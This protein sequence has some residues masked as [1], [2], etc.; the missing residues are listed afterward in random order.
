[1]VG[2]KTERLTVGLERPI[3]D[4]SEAL[5]LELATF[6]RG[7]NSDGPWFFGG[8]V[9]PSFQAARSGLSTA[10]HCLQNT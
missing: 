10:A 7:M 3:Q 2:K 1:M 9:A 8:V 4:A 6:T 5:D